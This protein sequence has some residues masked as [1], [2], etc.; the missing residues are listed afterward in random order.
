MIP[1]AQQDFFTPESLGTFAGASAAV[2]AIANAISYVVGRDWKVLPFL[3]SLGVSFALAAGGHALKGVDDWLVA[4]AN[5][6]LLFCTAVGIQITALVTASGKEVSNRRKHAGRP[7][8][9][10]PWLRSWMPPRT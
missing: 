8:A 2:F 1:L 6:C 7:R 9:S 10:G 4:F 5:G 3:V